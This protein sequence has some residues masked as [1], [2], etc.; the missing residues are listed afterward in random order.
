M[1]KFVL[2]L[3]LLPATTIQAQ[4]IHFSQYWESPLNLSP[5]LAGTD[6]SYARA[7]LNYRSQWG[8]FGKAFQTMGASFDMPFQNRRDKNVYLGGGLNVYHDRAGEA[9]LAKL[10]IGGSL[11]SVLKISRNQ[12]ISIGV[13]GALNQRSIN[14]N[15]V[16]WDSQFNG[17]RYDAALASGETHGSLSR[18]FADIGVGAAWII[19]G[20][21]NNF[22]RQE[23]FGMTLGAGVFHLNRP[24]QAFQGS[25][26]T[27]IRYNGFLRMN[28]ATGKSNVSIQPL[29][30][31]W[32]Q[33][34]LQEINAGVML[35][36]GL[37]SESQFTGY[38]RGMAISVGAHYRVK[39]AIYPVILYEFAD[40][41]IGVSYDVNIS[42]LTPYSQARGGFEISLRYRDLNGLLFN[43]G[44]K[45]AKFL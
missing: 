40:Y 1:K 45:H 2:L 4:D 24:N 15:D 36:Y 32:R 9:G 21:T 7:N 5:A 35:R 18:S 22:T 23:S 12:L 13:Q 42:S 38:K 16:S 8:S 44:G 30:S 29:F 39:D 31:Y 43:Q 19:R 20:I 27:R 33:G 41:A 10:N 11:S 28:L 17:V 6:A 14:L 34:S 3:F 37:K 26:P 25:D